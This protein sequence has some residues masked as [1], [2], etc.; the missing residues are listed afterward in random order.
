MNQNNQKFSTIFVHNLSFPYLNDYPQV[1]NRDQR[2]VVCAKSGDTVLTNNKIDPNYIDY[3][4][5]RGWDFSKVKFYSLSKTDKPNFD[6]VFTDSRLVKLVTEKKGFCIDTYHLTKVEDSFSKQTKLPLLGNIKVAMKYGSKSGLR[7]L[8]KKLSLSIPDGHE[9]IKN[10]SQAMKAINLLK[11]KDKKFIVIKTDY[12][13]D[14]RGTTLIN[15]ERFFQ[16]P[17]TKREDVVHRAFTKLSSDGDTV[18]IEE[19][20]PNVVSSPAVIVNISPEKKINMLAIYDQIL[21]GKTKVY[22]GAEFPSGSLSRTQIC[23]IKKMTFRLANLLL[24]K[25][26]E[27]IFGLDFVLTKSGQVYLI[28]ANLRKVGTYYP[29]IAM[30]RMCGNHKNMHFKYE[31]IESDFLKGKDFQS[32]EKIVSSNIFR[33]K[34]KGVMVLYVG[35]LK[36]N[37]RIEVVCYGQNPQQIELLS[38]LVNNL[39]YNYHRS[40]SSFTRYYIKNILKIIG[41]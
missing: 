23:K 9:Y 24:R 33:S 16:C 1:L 11:G 41:L 5:R 17:L 6:S 19:W 15:L 37:G 26:Y 22:S 20:V 27:G 12:G 21:R 39:L 35:E 7:R 38:E 34:D 4:S 32:V 2:C 18:S 28:E 8:A 29:V 14:G 25:G 13:A 10:K 40:F 3:L 31:V 30:K 36:S